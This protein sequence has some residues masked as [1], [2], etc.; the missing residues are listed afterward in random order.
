VLRE[1]IADESVDL[2][3][4]DQP[5]NSKANYNILF[6]SK[7]GDGSDAQIE[8]SEGRKSQCAPW[9]WRRLASYIWL[10]KP[11]VPN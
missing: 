6:K 11:N 4:L 10:T 3:Y 8:R 9:E 5:F 7:T 2:I 1:Q